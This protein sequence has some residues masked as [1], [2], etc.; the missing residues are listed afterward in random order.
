MK[1]DLSTLE[2]ILLVRLSA[3][4]DC[5]AAAPVFHALRKRFP[6]AH[7]A[8]AVQDNFA[9]LLSNLQGLDEIIVF[10]RRRWIHSKSRWLPWMEAR[11]FIRHLRLRRFQLAVDVQ[12]N[13][14]SSLIAFLSR[15]PVRIGHGGV[16]ARELSA[17]FNTIRIVPTPGEDHIVQRNL[18]LLRPLG[19]ES[20]EP[21]FT[22]PPDPYARR[23]ILNWL[24]GQSLREQSYVLLVPFCGRPEKEW[25]RAHFSELAGRLAREGRPVVMLLSPGREPETQDLLSPAAPDG[26][27]LGPSAGIPEMV[28]LVRL[29]QACAGGDTGPIQIAGALGIPNVCLFGPTDPQRLRPWSNSLTLPLTA[30]PAAVLDAIH[31]MGG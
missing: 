5:L 30:D 18:G 23:R 12:S 27:F 10:P 31:R 1:L 11:R 21:D 22:L 9:P 19:I 6:Q 16:E 25:P 20:A 4:G 7:I 26:V 24:Y 29:A 28:E 8:W 15:A 2:R 17:W 3:L 14:K 13:A